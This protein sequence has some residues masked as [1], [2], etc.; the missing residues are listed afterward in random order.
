VGVDAVVHDVA[1]QMVFPAPEQVPREFPQ[2]PELAVGR[3]L[4]GLQLL[5]LYQEALLLERLLQPLPG[6]GLLVLA[7]RVAPGR[8]LRAQRVERGRTG[9]DGRV[10]TGLQLEI[11]DRRHLV[12]HAQVQRFLHHGRAV[13]FVNQVTYVGLCEH[14]DIFY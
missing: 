3:A 6:Q 5:R 4:R 9:G 13:V 10:R 11:A 7:L 2:L 14:K 1:G 8:L 12:P